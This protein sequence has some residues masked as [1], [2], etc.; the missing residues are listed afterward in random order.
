MEKRLI[1][2]ASG[3]LGNI[4]LPLSSCIA[5][6]KETNR[7]PV[8]CWEPTFRCM[9]T[10][11][12]IFDDEIEVINKEQLLLYNDVKVYGD[13]F[14]I[15]YD[16]DLYHD[17]SLRS[18][19]TKFMTLPVSLLKKDDNQE[20]VIIYHNN[21]IPSVGTNSSIDVLKN[22]KI[23]QEIL[24]K[25]E[26]FSLK[27]FQGLE[28]YGAHARG[29]DFNNPIDFYLNGIRELI[30]KNKDCKI[31]LCS[32]SPEWEKQILDLYPDNIILRNKEHFVT[33][34]SDRNPGWS[35]NALTSKEAVIEGLIDM[36]LLTKTNFSVYNSNSSFAQVVKHLKS[37]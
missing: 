24:E 15:N 3:G 32:D 13:Y 8:I 11:K 17:Y 20:N 14:D 16:G 28:V 31:F 36:L 4:L 18:V 22:L 27:N 10:F 37:N 35:N 1:N 7:K 23:K 29:T 2:Y 30:N 26:E 33:R 19:V 25:V 6:A 21:I 9:A 5:L 34:L 12:D